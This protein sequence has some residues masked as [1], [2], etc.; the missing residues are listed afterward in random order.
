MGMLGKCKHTHS[1]AHT[2]ALL[3]MLMHLNVCVSRVHVL[4]LSTYTHS[5]F[6]LPM[7]HILTQRPEFARKK[8]II[9]THMYIQ[10]EW[11]WTRE[12][13][14]RGSKRN[15][16]PV[17]TKERNL[18]QWIHYTVNCF[19]FFP[20]FLHSNSRIRKTSEQKNRIS[21]WNKKKK[22]GTIV[23]SSGVWYIWRECVCVRECVLFR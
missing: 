4:L 12:A 21:A 1:L 10:S 11:K 6:R 14:R 20:L 18:L 15:W 2:C 13:E 19:T 8:W 22:Y 7:K 17:A 23:N 5:F 3:L 9:Y 16:Q